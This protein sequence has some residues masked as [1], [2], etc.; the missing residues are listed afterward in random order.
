MSWRGLFHLTAI[1]ALGQKSL[2]KLGVTPVLKVFPDKRKA[3]EILW[4][5][6]SGSDGLRTLL[7]TSVSD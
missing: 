7:K 4:I 6:V 3:L 2:D 5:R 1:D